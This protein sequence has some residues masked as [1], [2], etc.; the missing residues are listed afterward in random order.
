[1]YFLLVEGGGIVL[2]NKNMG[3]ATN[4]FKN[5]KSTRFLIYT[6]FIVLLGIG[7]ILLLSATDDNC[8]SWLTK[9]DDCWNKGI[10]N[11]WSD[12]LNDWVTHGGPKDFCHKFPDNVI[13]NLFKSSGNFC[14]K[15]P[16]ICSMIPVPGPA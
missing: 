7:L 1:M 4:I 13:C 14:D 6:I 12:K 2:A 15:H 11:A 10:I 8:P 16:K 9:P 3:L 5:L